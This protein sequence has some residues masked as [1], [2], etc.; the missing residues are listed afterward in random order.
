MVREIEL[1]D[2]AESAGGGDFQKVPANKEKVM[3]LFVLF[4][5]CVYFVMCKWIHGWFCWW[6]FML[7]V[8]KLMIGMWLMVII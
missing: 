3:F 6:D 8:L 7:L 1:F 5:L 4:L 2:Q